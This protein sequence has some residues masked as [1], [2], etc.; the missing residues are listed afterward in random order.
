MAAKR[1]PGGGRKPIPIEK[2]IGRGTFDKSRHTDNTASFEVVQELEAPA[3]LSMEGKRQYMK[4]GKKLQKIGVLKDT[5]L[6]FFI[7]LSLIAAVTSTLIL[8]NPWVI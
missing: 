8:V 4:I 2:H 5:D 6:H 3:Y 1:A 7:I